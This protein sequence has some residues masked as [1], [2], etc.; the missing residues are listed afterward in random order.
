MAKSPKLEP[1]LVVPDCHI[2]YHDHRAWN[3]ML[4]V[5]R[6]LKPRHLYVIG[7][8]VDFY[9]VSDHSKDPRR[10]T[11]LADEVNEANIYLNQLDLLGAKEKVYVSGNHEDRLQRYLQ[12]KAPEL[13]DVLDVAKLLKLK[14]RGWTYVPYKRHSKLGKV[15]FTHDVGT[16]GRTAIFQC[17]DSYQHSVVTGHTHRMAYIVEGNA[18][19]EQKLSAQFGWLGNAS[20]IDYMHYAKVLKNWA[21]GFG[22]GYVNPKTGL[23]YLTP[24]PLVNYSCV[25]NG[26]FYSG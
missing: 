9:A 3:L 18:L 25:V 24:I 14:D 13:F 23:V 26:T 4:K 6:D 15:H 11:Q 1:I 17:L 12:N 20:K 7:D 19:G 22:V 8:F 16:A 5:G 21:L 10:T 2:P